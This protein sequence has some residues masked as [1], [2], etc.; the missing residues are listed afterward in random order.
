ME[1]GVVAIEGGFGAPVWG[2][3]VRPSSDTSRL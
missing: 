2:R 3:G 1:S